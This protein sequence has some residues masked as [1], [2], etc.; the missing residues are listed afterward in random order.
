MYSIQ[1]F[2]PLHYKPPLS[3]VHK[4]KLSLY[5]Y[6]PVFLV[7]ITVIFFICNYSLVQYFLAISIGNLEVKPLG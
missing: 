3:E 4:G 7:G 5:F 1:L 2:T 6:E